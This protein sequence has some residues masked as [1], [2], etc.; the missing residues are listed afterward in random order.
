MTRELTPAVEAAF[1]AE[2][3]PLLCFVYLDFT[4]EPLRATNAPYAVE[5]NGETWLGLGRLGR[6]EEIKEG[7]ESASY[8]LRLTLSGIPND[9]IAKAFATHYQ[10][11]LVQIWEA[12]LTAQYQVIADPVEVWRGYMDTMN[13]RLGEMAEV[14]LLCESKLAD[15]DRARVR[16][17]NAE[18]QAIDYPDDKGL[19][20]VP[21][22]VEKELVWGRG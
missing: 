14:E 12:P 8:G 6:I 15:W 16:R 19:E 10:G 20:F 18:D 13:I 22:M 1:E 5:W 11:R 9:I 21:Q 3:V 2:N 17:Y 4:D 7:V